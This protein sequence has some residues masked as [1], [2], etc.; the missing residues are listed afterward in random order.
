[1]ASNK[2]FRIAFVVGGIVFLLIIASIVQAMLP[3]DTSRD[4]LLS[5]AQ[6]QTE[7]AR[8]SDLGTRAKTREMRY[9]AINS[10]LVINSDRIAMLNYLKKNG[11]SFKDKDL[12]L[13]RN[14]KTDADL[15]TA[16]ASSTYDSAFKTLFVKA[17]NDYG[18]ALQ[19][20]Q[21]VT[22]GV[23]EQ[24]MLASDIEHLKLLLEQADATGTN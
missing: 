14:P 8:V 10:N 22:T 23:N 3:K 2:M 21:G 17:L 19:A 13:K 15:K 4:E 16:T 9:F 20:R 5:I 12:A 7:L 11:F 1:M 6:T 18:S 24:K